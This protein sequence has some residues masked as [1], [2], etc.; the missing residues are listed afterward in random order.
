MSDVVQV[1]KALN[2]NSVEIKMSAKGEPTFNVKAY[3]ET[4]KEAMI[5]AI[6]IFDKLK[7]KYIDK[8]EIDD[9]DDDDL[10]ID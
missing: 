7:Q 4:T 2:P 1:T 8:E 9:L 10:D 3:G 6:N 5:E